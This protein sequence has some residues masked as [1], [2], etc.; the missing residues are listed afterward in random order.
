MIYD[1]L[2]AR[3]GPTGG[4][5]ARLLAGQ[6]LRWDK[7]DDSYGLSWARAATFIRGK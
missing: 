2:R 7:R 3:R 5:K 6:A 1:L 4:D